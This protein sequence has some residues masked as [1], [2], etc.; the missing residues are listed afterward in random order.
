MEAGVRDGR[1]RVGAKCVERRMWV[2]ALHTFFWERQ[3]F[4]GSRGRQGPTVAD[5]DC[6]CGQ[7][8]K[9]LWVVDV[10][11]GVEIRAETLM[12]RGS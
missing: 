1:R 9:P 5:A 7:A 4:D 6:R 8:A 10:V 3:V 11:C 12:L 2:V